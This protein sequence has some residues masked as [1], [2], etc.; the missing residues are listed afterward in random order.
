MHR[1]IFGPGGGTALPNHIIIENNTVYNEPGGGIYIQGADYVQILNNNVHDNAH[2]SAFGNSG[3]SVGVSQLL[4]NG[5]APHI[6]IEGNTSVNNAELVPEIRA[7][8]VTDGEGIN[9]DTNPGYTG[10][11]LIQGN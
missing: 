5:P 1:P 9:I 6:I 10:G 7:G 2:W 4:D 3:I 8:A 11:F